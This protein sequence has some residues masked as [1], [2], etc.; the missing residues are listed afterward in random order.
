MTQP[1]STEIRDAI[2]GVNDKF[3]EAFNRGDAAG[4]VSA[5]YT[6]NAQILPTNSDIIEGT[7]GIHYP[8]WEDEVSA[9]L[10]YSGR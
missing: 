6:S 10:C 2:A 8:S 1:T 3:L 7:E 4:C 5:T 9:Y